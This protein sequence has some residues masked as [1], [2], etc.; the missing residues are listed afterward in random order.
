MTY[1][2]EYLQFGE[3]QKR[4]P[5]YEED[6][7]LN[8][9]PYDPVPK[10]LVEPDPSTAQWGLMFSFESG[11]F[12]AK[13]AKVPGQDGAVI[14][15]WYAQGG[16]GPHLLV[17]T[18]FIVGGSN[19][20]FAQV[21]KFVDFSETSI[22]DHTVN[23]DTIK[24][25]SVIATVHAELPEYAKFKVSTQSTSHS[26]I[27]TTTNTNTVFDRIFVYYGNGSVINNT[28]TVAKAHTVFALAVFK[29]VVSSSSVEVSTYQWPKIPKWEWPMIVAEIVNEIAVKANGEIYQYL[30]PK[31][32][33]DA[34][35]ETQRK[36]INSI[37]ARIEEL[38]KIKSVIIGLVE[39]NVR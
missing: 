34:G 35:V 19:E 21:S 6:L 39:K 26:I 11:A 23:T 16:P 14:K 28:L 20:G 31:L 37:S 9:K 7:Q 17:L 1:I 10:K 25:A 12:Y 8:N 30:S 5:G 2:S 3:N 13:D 33:A 29:E 38:D 15:S 24:A 36:A 4:V 27:I 22:D 32:I 18:P